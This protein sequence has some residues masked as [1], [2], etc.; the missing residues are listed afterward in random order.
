MN[1]TRQ[2]NSEATEAT[3]HIELIFKYY[4]RGQFDFTY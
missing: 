3:E 2:S 1:T 4:F